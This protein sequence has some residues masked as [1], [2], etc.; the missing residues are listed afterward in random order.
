MREGIDYDYEHD[1]EH[2]QGRF[3]LWAQPTLAFFGGKTIAS[4]KVCRPSLND[5]YGLRYDILI[6]PL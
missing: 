5:A 4:R 6:S 2:E 1:Y 3:G